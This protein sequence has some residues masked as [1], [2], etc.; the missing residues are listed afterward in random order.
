MTCDGL[1]ATQM[2][3]SIFVWLHVQL[4]AAKASESI[5]VIGFQR[6]AK[7]ANILSDAKGED[8]RH[9]RFWRGRRNL[10]VTDAIMRTIHGYGPAL[11]MCKAGSPSL[12]RRGVSCGQTVLDVEHSTAAKAALAPLDSPHE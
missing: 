3:V 6:S 12:I 8:N 1:G 9:P 11:R 10:M 2:V 5:Q 7:L 4:A